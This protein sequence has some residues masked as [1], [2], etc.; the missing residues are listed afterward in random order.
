VTS[1]IPLKLEFKY[2]LTI[3][4]VAIE[5]FRKSFTKRANQKKDL[6]DFI[7]IFQQKSKPKESKQKSKYKNLSF[8]CNQKKDF[9]SVKYL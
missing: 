7:K 9:A 3:S 1:F 8:G 4:R 5:A 2:V 6:K